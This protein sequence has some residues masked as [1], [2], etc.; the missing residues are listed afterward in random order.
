MCIVTRRMHCSNHARHSPPPSPVLRVCDPSE[1]MSTEL[2]FC[3][4]LSPP[5][6]PSAC[7]APHATPPR[8]EGLEGEGWLAAPLL[9]TLTPPGASARAAAAAP[10]SCIF[11]CVFCVCVCFVCVCK[12]VCVCVCVRV[13]V[14]VCK[15]YVCVRQCHV[16]ACERGASVGAC[17]SIYLRMCRSWHAYIELSIASNN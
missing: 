14:C 1:P 2:F 5:A 16:S 6:P 8:E 3:C 4:P 10:S 7:A 13:C 11:V 12:C 17:E 15:C 9:L